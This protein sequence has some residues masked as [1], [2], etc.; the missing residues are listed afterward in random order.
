MAD[1]TVT[2]FFFFNTQ[3]QTVRYPCIDGLDDFLKECPPLQASLVLLECEHLL[4]GL[5]MA[6]STA[7]VYRFRGVDK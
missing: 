1:L 4:T 3:L 2:F 6:Y 5:Q 7:V